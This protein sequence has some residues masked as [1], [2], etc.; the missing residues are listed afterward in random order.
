ML[1]TRLPDEGQ[2]R[3]DVHQ[4]AFARLLGDSDAMW[5]G[6][7]KQI[8]HPFSTWPA[9]GASAVGVHAVLLSSARVLGD[10]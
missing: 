7:R 4:C 5:H 6:S 1:K 10:N 9:G 8:A 3:S 2:Q